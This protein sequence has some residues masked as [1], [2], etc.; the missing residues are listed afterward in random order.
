MCPL[1][2]MLNVSLLLVVWVCFIDMQGCALFMCCIGLSSKCVVVFW[3][4]TCVIPTL[5]TNVITTH[6]HVCHYYLIL[7]RFISHVMGVLY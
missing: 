4:S 6:I 3:N 5:V 2:I 7:S 1:N